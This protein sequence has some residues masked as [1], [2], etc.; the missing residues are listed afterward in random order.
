MRK[1]VYVLRMVAMKTAMA[2]ECASRLE[3]EPS[4]NVTMAL[5]MM[6]WTSAPDVRTLSCDTQVN[7]TDDD[8]GSLNQMTA[9]VILSLTTCHTNC[10]KFKDK[11]MRK[12]CPISLKPSTR[13]QMDQQSGEED[14][15][16]ARPKQ[17]SKDLRPRE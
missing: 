5:H 4:V 8:S 9:N 10:S 7:V 11:Y 16:C 13:L 2:M 3:A 14:M 12:A 1:A 15:P 6:D 17:T